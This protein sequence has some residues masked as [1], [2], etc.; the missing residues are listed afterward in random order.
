MLDVIIT[1]FC[2]NIMFLINHGGNMFSVQHLPAS[3]A[4]LMPTSFGQPSRTYSFGSTH[5]YQN[6]HIVSLV[7]LG[8]S[9][10]CSIDEAASARMQWASALCRDYIACKFA[11]TPH[12]NI[13]ADINRLTLGTWIA[14][15]TPFCIIELAK[16]TRM[17]ARGLCALHNVQ[18]LQTRYIYTWSVWCA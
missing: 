13:E 11:W 18:Y 14:P 4:T 17:D 15:I 12:T 9:R 10:F 3:H 5:I 2:R 1:M 8:R 7:N 16:S 6:L